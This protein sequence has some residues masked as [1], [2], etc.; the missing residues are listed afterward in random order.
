M[1][2]AAAFALAICL[3]VV[4]AQQFNAFK[5]YKES[6]VKPPHYGTTVKRSHPEE[7]YL[8]IPQKRAMRHRKS[9]GNLKGGVTYTDTWTGNHNSPNYSRKLYTETEGLGFVQ[10]CLFAVVGSLLFALSLV[11][12]RHQSKA[13]SAKEIAPANGIERS[14]DVEG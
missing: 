14:V 5:S 4:Q 10:W 9:K 7:E 8:S 12:E 6:G 13:L 3:C 1:L 2:L 11:R